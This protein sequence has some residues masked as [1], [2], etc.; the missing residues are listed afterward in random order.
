MTKRSGYFIGGLLGLIAV[1]GYLLLHGDIYGSSI[2]LL[3]LFGPLGAIAGAIFGG[4]S[5]AV[6]KAISNGNKERIQNDHSRLR[7]LAALLLLTLITTFILFNAT[8]LLAVMP[9][10]LFVCGLI[11]YLLFA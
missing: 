7:I 5:V 3:P 1:T 10:V 11:V 6:T 8:H 4:L 2:G 9:P